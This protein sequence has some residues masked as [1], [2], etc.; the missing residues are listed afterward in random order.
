M[1][2]SGHG[3]RRLEGSGD[4]GATWRLLDGRKGELF[5]ARH[6]AKAYRIEDGNRRECNVFRSRQSPPLLFA[7]K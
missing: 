4:G 2:L 5:A 6:L 7:A 1:A 3:V